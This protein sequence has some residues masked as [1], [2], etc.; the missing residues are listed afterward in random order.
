MR[1]DLTRP[2]EQWDCVVVIR[3]CDVEILHPSKVSEI[4]LD[5]VP[6]IEQARARIG[7]LRWLW[8]AVF[9]H[10]PRELPI[11]HELERQRMIARAATAEWNHPFIDELTGAELCMLIAAVQGR[12]VAWHRAMVVEAQ[13]QADAAT[14]AV[15]DRSRPV[16]RPIRTPSRGEPVRAAVVPGE[17][18]PGFLGA[19]PWGR[20][21]S[22][23]NDTAEQEVNAG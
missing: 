16:D 23:Q 10:T 5:V 21:V 14:P 8:R 11:D 13:R 7:L 6:E 3:G 18:L 4:S 19:Q 17:P 9:G 1:I 22:S 2:F 15:K 20:M 12:Q